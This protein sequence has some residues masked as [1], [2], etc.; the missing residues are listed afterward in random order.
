LQVFAFPAQIHYPTFLKKMRV[1]LDAL[2]L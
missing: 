2:H 1:A